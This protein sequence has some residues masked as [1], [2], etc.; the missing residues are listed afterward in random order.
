MRSA[1]ASAL[2]AM[3]PSA[4][5]ENPG[6]CSDVARSRKSAGIGLAVEGGGPNAP[7][8]SSVRNGATVSTFASLATPA[9][10]VDVKPDIS[11]ILLSISTKEPDIGRSDQRM[12]ALT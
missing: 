12:S 4:G 11:T 5:P 8:P 1:A 9:P 2:T 10:G 7:K 3:G 6:G